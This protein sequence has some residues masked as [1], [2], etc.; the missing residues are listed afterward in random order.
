MFSGIHNIGHCVN[1][2]SKGIRK[3]GLQHSF[4]ITPTKLFKVCPIKPSETNL[5][6]ILTGCFTKE[7]KIQK[8]LPYVLDKDLV[9]RIFNQLQ[10]YGF[11]R[12]IQMGTLNQENLDM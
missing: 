2:F 3:F 12:Y 1:I 11:Q 8:L 5:R 9:L 6:I 10:N 4:N 7:E